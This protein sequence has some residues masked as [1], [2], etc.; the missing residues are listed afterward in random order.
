VA[1]FP[2]TG[3][4]FVIREGVNG[5]LDA[6]LRAAAMRALSISHVSCRESAASYS[7]EA[8]TRQFQGNL[9]INH[10]TAPV[11]HPCPVRG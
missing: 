9:A 8:C 6:D 11:A 10:A 3:P 2:V 1:A 5:C 4:K 7:W